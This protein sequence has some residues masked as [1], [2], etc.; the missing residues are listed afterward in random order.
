[1]G[2]K[3]VD[4][5]YFGL[6]AYIGTTKHM[7]G[8]ETTARLID[9]CHVEKGTYVLDVGCG[10]G[11]TAAYLAKEVGARVMAV[12][13]REAMVALMQERA[14]RDGVAERVDARVADAQSLP[15]DEATFDAVLCESV[16]TFIEDKARV[17][18]E[19]VRVVKPSGY[20]GLNEE[21]WLRAPTPEMEDYAARVWSI[22]G[23]IPTAQRWEQILSGAGFSEVEIHTLSY[24]LQRESTQLKRYRLGDMLRM[25]YRV[26]GLYLKSGAFREYMAERKHMPK[27]LFDYLGYALLVCRR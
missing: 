8:L 13:L 21:I 14:A 26:L 9:L 27:G 5:S 12:D 1:M 7:G 2:A 17:A 23:Q 15:F 24:D 25:A 19:F 6:Q 16:A 10:A 4:I 22:G 18:R 3:V 20:V 11:A